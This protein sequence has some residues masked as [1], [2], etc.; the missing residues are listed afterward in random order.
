MVFS[1]LALVLL[2]EQPISAGTANIR[3]DGFEFTVAGAY[4][5]TICGGPFLFDKGMAYQ[6]NAGEYQITI[7][8]ENRATGNVPLNTKDGKNVNVSV[9]VNGKG[10]SLVRHASNG[11]RLIV[12]EDF[13]KAE[14]TLELRPVVG[15]GNSSLRATFICK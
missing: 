7:A 5:A 3:I 11:G 1:F 6:V 15:R 9:T 4:P 14:A 13:K 12:S 8:S 10:K 2:T